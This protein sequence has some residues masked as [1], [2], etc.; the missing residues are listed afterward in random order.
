MNG[1]W[2]WVIPFVTVMNSAFLTLSCI[3]EGASKKVLQVLMPPEPI[4]NKSICFNE[5]KW[6]L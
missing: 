5:Q 1:K 4:Y 6:L 2:G 3:I